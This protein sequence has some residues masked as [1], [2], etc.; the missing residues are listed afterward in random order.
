[1]AVALK[2]RPKEIADDI[3]SALSA[4]NIIGSVADKLNKK[5]RE[6]NMGVP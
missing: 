4:V 5:E 2:R 1:M 3:R 6:A